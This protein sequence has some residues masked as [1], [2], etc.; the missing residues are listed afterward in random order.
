MIQPMRLEN[1][2][3]PVCRA[4]DLDI[5]SPEENWL[6]RSI[7]GYSAVGMIGGAPKCCKSWL[8]LDMAVSVASGTNCLG[9]FEV[10]QKGVV[11][12]FLAEDA[13][14]N[15]RERLESICLSRQIDLKKLNL[16]VIT[17]SSLRLDSKD[18]QTLLKKTLQEYRPKLLLLD[19]LVRLH[20]LDENSA[21][22][23][24]RLLGFVRYLQRAY[25][26]AIVL[27][28]HA[29]KK[30]RSQPGQTLRGSSDLHAFGDSNAY[31][32]RRK[33]RLILQLEHR[34]A[35]P[36]S[37]IEIRLVS[38][39]DGSN[40][41]LEA[42]S[43]ATPINPEISLS[44]RILELIGKTE[45]PWRRT[46]IRKQLM[47]NNQMLGHA[48][49]ALEENNLI[50]RTSKGWMGINCSEVETKPEDGLEQLKS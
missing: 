18:D 15:V 34:S 32:S 12:A 13:L 2:M 47:V 3:L 40:T 6:I 25:D 37:P 1:K 10:V 5:K 27:V 29:S 20:R 22:D 48:L 11:L 16:Y 38:E 24:S 28:H 30:Q 26:T 8:G 43:L 7:W 9:C 36:E 21:A 23:I 45:K 39:K 42:V 31:L 17:S 4:Y 33:D 49:T 35:K 50:Q 19:P 44:D 46:L 41:H 14:S